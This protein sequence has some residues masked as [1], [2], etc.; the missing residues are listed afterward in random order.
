MSTHNICYRSKTKKYV[1]PANPS[2]YYV[3]VGYE[4]LCISQTCYPD[5]H[6]SDTNLSMVIY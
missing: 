3:K 2:F 1:Y 4:G 5:V 6:I